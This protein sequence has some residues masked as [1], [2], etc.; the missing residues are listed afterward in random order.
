MNGFK[1]GASRDDP[2]AESTTDIDPDPES[3]PTETE[4]SDD[5]SDD[6]QST[7]RDLPWIYARDSITDGRSK[8]VQL[9]LQES[10]IENQREAKTAVENELGDTVKKADLREAA[11]LV[12]MTHVDEVADV[13]REWG[14][15]IE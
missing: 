7:S 13:L 8:T 6:K 12:G 11:L 4:Q 2:F 14:Y 10:T 1:S 5:D 9:H 3:V 15:G